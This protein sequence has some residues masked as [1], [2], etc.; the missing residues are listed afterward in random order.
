MPVSKKRTTSTSEAAKVESSD[1]KMPD[2]QDFCQ[3]MRNLAVSTMRVLIEEV[4]Q[5]T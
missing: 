5:G 3:H 2:E 1:H 4:V